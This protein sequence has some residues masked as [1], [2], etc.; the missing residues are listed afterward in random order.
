M[1]DSGG[2]AEP[3]GFGGGTQEGANASNALEASSG[4]NGPGSIEFGATRADWGAA[5]QTVGGVITVGAG[6]LSGN[7]GLATFGGAVTLA[8]G[9]LKS[10]DS[11]AAVMNDIATANNMGINAAD[12]TGL[13]SAGLGFGWHGGV[14]INYADGQPVNG[15]IALGG[16]STLLA[17]GTVV[18][19][20]SWWSSPSN[21]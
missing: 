6:V 18:V 4:G 17:N 11:I 14:L 5:L 15:G 9:G 8:G 20:Q 21:S 10:A 2:N 12:L 13:N 3:G 16:G 1:N 7:M 19:D